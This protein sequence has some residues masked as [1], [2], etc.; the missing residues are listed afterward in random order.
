MAIVEM[1][2]LALLAVRS[3]KARV[4]R[5]LQRLGCTEIE[6][7]PLEEAPLARPAS[8]GELNVLE[9]RM[10]RIGWTIR[11]L[12]KYAPKP[13]F[14][15]GFGGPEP[16]SPE[17][18]QRVQDREDEL[19]RTV[20][21]AEA[22]ERRGGEL[23]AQEA[24]LFSSVDQFRPWTALDVPLEQIGS[25][26]NT[27]TMLLT[28]P[29]KNMQALQDALVRAN[30]PAAVRTVS[31]DPSVC[32]LW[33]VCHVGATDALQM[34][35]KE[36]EATQVNFP[37]VTGTA[38][39][40][41][42]AMETQLAELSVE[43]ANIQAD[44]TK[45]TGDIA[46]LKVLHDL[47]QARVMR[48]SAAQR[49]VETEQTFYARAW[50]PAVQAE[51]L[52][53]ALRQT[54][55]TCAVE[56]TDPAEDEKPP[57][58][59]KNNWLNTQFEGIVDGYS[60]P[61]PRGLDPT[62]IMAPFFACFFGLMLSDAGY[63]LLLAI[64]I[65][66]IVHFIKP[67]KGSQRLLWVLAIGGVFTVFWGAMLNTWFGMAPWPVLLNP[68][69]QPMEMM[70]LC[71]G[72]GFIHLLTAMGIAAYMN[73]RSGDWLAAV[74]DQFCWIAI[75]FGIGMIFLPPTALI[76]KI[77]AIGGALGILFFAGRDKPKFMSRLM[78]G[79]GALY[80][81]SSWLGDILSYSRLFGMGL[82]TGVIG[83]VINM[84]GAMVLKSGPVGMVFGVIVLIIGHGFNMAIN[85]LG[86]YVHAC[87][88]Q[89]IEFFNKF[90]QEGGVAFKPLK[91]ETRYVDL[92]RIES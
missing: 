16:V 10:T 63:G 7:L 57:T 50:V 51:P 42:L 79:A 28:V 36:A 82:A 23:H 59:L 61:D 38:E 46:D 64:C 17:A 75:L 15:A 44:W 24:R 25:T 91:G 48:L 11:Q 69:E 9:A 92:S 65:P 60:L 81:I 14:L 5:L 49:F 45:L 58:L 66:L 62:F 70:A 78:S 33:A 55:P 86:A 31:S 40:N 53:K 68:M 90:Y 20:E 85:V 27:R 84:L 73:I 56:I 77:L 67:K 47:C 52:E 76:G 8:E 72:L 19:M 26:H 30:L 41:K 32:Y 74:I 43:K 29:G 3:D 54:S 87:R 35:L 21:A 6:Q 37:G 13:G 12:T 1:K 89:Y 34:L 39:Q 88:L 22:C 2:H 83:M 4:L 80:G 71:L 18:A